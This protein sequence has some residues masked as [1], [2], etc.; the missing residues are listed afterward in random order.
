MYYVAMQ[1]TRWTA[2]Q[3]AP[4]P[5]I[6]SAPM[7][8]DAAKAEAAKRNEAEGRGTDGPVYTHYFVIQAGE[9]SA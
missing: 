7:D 8:L 3:P 6:I 1:V 5:K 9:A 4:M 2:G